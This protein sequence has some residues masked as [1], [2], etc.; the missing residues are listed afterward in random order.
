MQTV[1]P[2]GP[3]NNYAIVPQMC[4]AEY[5]NQQQQK[6]YAPTRLSQRFTR[7]RLIPP[8]IWD[9]LTFIYRYLSLYGRNP[10]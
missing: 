1:N 4:Y 6:G 5:P 2:D 8:H 3:F 7:D 9:Q 10:E